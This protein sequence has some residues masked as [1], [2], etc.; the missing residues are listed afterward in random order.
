MSKKS[1]SKKKK[2]KHQRG[3]EEGKGAES[4]AAE[5]GGAASGDAA[6][7][8]TPDTRPPPSDNVWRWEVPCATVPFAAV[9]LLSLSLCH[10]KEEAGL[11]TSAV[12][13]LDADEV[14]VTDCT[15]GASHFP[16]I[17]RPLVPPV[18]GDDEGS[19]RGAG[20]TRPGH[21]RRHSGHGQH[22]HHH[23]HHHERSHSGSSSVYSPHVATNGDAVHSPRSS[24]HG[25]ETG[26]F[27]SVL[28]QAT[29]TDARGNSQAASHS[30]RHPVNA[31]AHL[32]PKAS[33]S[34][35][36]STLSSRLLRERMRL[37][38]ESAMAQHRK[39]EAEAVTP[40]LHM[41][42]T[43]PRKDARMPRERK[44]KHNPYV[45]KAWLPTST[46]H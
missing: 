22:S 42:I 6:A 9:T 35:I 18:G 31:Q 32:R 37:V 15:A 34:S 12:V 20:S 14:H 28:H 41:L 25:V 5:G 40:M 24:I 33:A 38:V 19:R 36:G 23:H 39:Q 1:K 26:G 7:A 2:R 17:I 27:A 45:Q 30:H 29:H 46:C 44:V 21:R 16:A 3:A 8:A 11:R 4:K 10:T 13:V 43:L